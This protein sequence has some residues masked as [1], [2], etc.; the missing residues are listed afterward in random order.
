MFQTPSFEGFP[1]LETANLRLR[2][3]QSSDAD[4]VFRIFSDEEVTRYYDFDTFVSVSQAVDL[5][6]RQANRFELG[7]GIRWGITQK[8]DNI[9]IGTCGYVYS[10]QNAQGG[11]GYDLGRS[12]WR[13]GIMSEALQLVIRFGF[14]TLRFNRIQALVIPGNVA[15]VKLLL[16]LGFKEEGTL[17]DYAFVRGQYHDLRCFSKLKR[18]YPK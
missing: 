3:L 6:T 7:E 17:R 1:Q 4:A 16:K 13:R 15:S 9:V 10:K 12:Y 5:I 18:D 11:I 2:R 8:A 14:K